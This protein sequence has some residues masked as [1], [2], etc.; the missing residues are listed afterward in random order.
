MAS[1]LICKGLNQIKTKHVTTFQL[2]RPKT[3]NAITFD[4]YHHLTEQLNLESKDPES[5]FVVLEGLNGNYSSG[6]DLSNF[7]KVDFSDVAG[8]KQAAQESGQMCQNFVDAFINCKKPIVAKVDGLCLGIM[9]T[10]LALCD[11]VYCTEKSKFT[12]PF[13]KIAQAPEGC[14]SVLFPEIFGA[15]QSREILLK[16]QSFDANL[17]LKAGFVNQ[18]FTDRQEMDQKVGTELE[19]MLKLPRRSFLSSRNLIKSHRRAELREVNRIECENLVERFS[20]FEELSPMISGF[21]SRK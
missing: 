21:F 6:N 15:H 19:K 13:T 8:L 16:S 2:D 5:T 10:T 20:D 14:S 7:L 17:A 3:M 4:M 9:C 1:K 11:F 12:T 18:V